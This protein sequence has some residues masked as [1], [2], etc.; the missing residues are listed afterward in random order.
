MRDVINDL[1][2]YWEK[3]R[4]VYNL[5]LILIVLAVFLSRMP[6][7]LDR[8]GFTLVLQ[9]FMLAVTANVLYC[10]AY[11]VDVFVQLSDFSERWKKVRWVLFV[12]GL[13]YAAINAWFISKNLLRPVI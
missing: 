8:L 12:I 5:V 2:R 1:I 11:V 7:S 13:F 9:L 10:T 6:E 4:I 3:R